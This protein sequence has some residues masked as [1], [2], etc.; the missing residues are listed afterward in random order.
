MPPTFRRGPVERRRSANPERL[1]D[2]LPRTRDGVA[3]LWAHQADVLRQYHSNFLDSTDVALELPTGAGKTLPA[4]L[5]AEWRRSSLD[6]R[7]AYACPTVQLAHQVH[8]EAMRQGIDAVALHG[9]HHKWDSI[10]AAKYESGRAIA[11]ITY[12]TVFNSNPAL[13]VPQTLL[14]DDAHA[15]EQYV[16]AAWSVNIRRAYDEDLY[17]QLL[18][19]ISSEL[20]DIHLQRLQTLDPDSFTRN[21]VKLLPLGA[22]RRCA[23]RIDRILGRLEG[24]L[25]F[26]YTMIRSAVERCLLYFGWQGFLLRPY[27]PPTSHHAHFAE[28]QHRVYISATLGEGGELERAFGT[29]NI[30]RLPSPA[31]WEQ[32]SSGRRFFV[33]P[34]FIREV[35]ARSLAKAVIQ[36]AGKVL[37]VAPSDRAL[38]TSRSS[39]LPPGMP[40]FGKGDI[41]RS[42]DSFRKASTGALALANRYDG[43]DL[44]DKS[45]RLT[46]LDGLPSGEHLQ[47][48]F[49]IRSLRAGRVLEERLR[50]RVIQ[51]AGRCTRGLKDHSVV[52][53]L[54]E[55]LTRFLQRTE[56]RSALRPEVQAEIDFGIVN[57]E[58]TEGEFRGAVRSCLDQDDNWQ[59]EAEP[60]IAELRREAKRA[61]PPGTEDLAVSAA[62]EV[63]AWSQAWEAD[64]L[65]ASQTAV[66][67]AQGVTDAALSP[68]RALWL[69][70]AA[71]WQGAAAEEAK[72]PALA[73]SASELLRKA[74]AAG[75]G[76]TW[77]RELA[78]LPPGEVILDELDQAAVAVVSAHRVRKLS[79][80]KWANLSVQLTNGLAGTESGA[81]ERALSILGDLLGAEA[82]KPGGKGR[83]D[84]VWIYSGLWWM[85]LEAKSESASKGLVSMENVRQANTQLRSLSED[86]DAPIPDGSV[87]LIIS[88]KT[89]TDPDAVPIADPHVRLCTPAEMRRLGEDTVE[90]WRDVRA[91]AMNLEGAQAQAVVRQRFAD[92]RLLPS[93]VRE[94]IAS[95]RVDG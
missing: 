38:E 61:M 48:R 37:V 4:L 27:I 57:S 42:L 91:T 55:E 29:A 68:Y 14:L 56:V 18:E 19:A 82:F 92:R 70:F 1:F 89:L 64:Y 20:Q 65:G 88:P 7:V 33:F 13:S 79:G 12:S 54:G 47:E 10:D 24:D 80:S 81:Y 90:A 39:L 36:D 66:D 50:T 77:L 76:M 46:V 41:E 43:I 84:S 58:V 87:S 9:T 78:P 32:R 67:V 44:A 21:D 74:H 6:E 30:A 5:I 62:K 40:A 94:R 75:K 63:R 59:N 53:I 8:A 60:Y 95:Q 85:T 26:R 31:G 15:G 73:A 45:C 51:G 35:D 52:I 72:D 49:L 69:Y 86:R 28:A 71:A 34:E 3:S 17:N 93:Q 16:A 22:L 83:A 25:R 23:P 11:V 2:D